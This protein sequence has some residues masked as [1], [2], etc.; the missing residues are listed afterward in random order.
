[1]GQLI[2]VIGFPLA[3]AFVGYAWHKIGWETGWW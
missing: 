3:G 1:M 2:F